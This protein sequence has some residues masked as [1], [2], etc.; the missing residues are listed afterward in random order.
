M[1]APSRQCCGLAVFLTSGENVMSEVISSISDRDRSL[2]VQAIC[3]NCYGTTVERAEAILAGIAVLDGKHFPILVWPKEMSSEGPSI[4]EAKAAW[5]KAQAE[6]YEKLLNQTADHQS[7][8]RSEVQTLMRNS[9]SLSKSE[10]GLPPLP[11]ASSARV[12]PEK[13][14]ENPSHQQLNEPSPNSNDA[15]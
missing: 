11:S 10:Q 5:H 12:P 6:G 14:K 7:S 2:A 13:D 15:C 4:W 3:S 9:S 8:S 1:V